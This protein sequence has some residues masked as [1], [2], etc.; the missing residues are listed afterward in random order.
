MTPVRKDLIL[1]TRLRKLHHMGI[2]R[3]Q[4]D[5]AAALALGPQ[6]GL[7]CTDRY[8]EHSDEQPVWFSQLPA[9]VDMIPRPC[10]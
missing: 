5:S 10:N 9:G 8:I 4:N 2:N 6:S 1:L 7:R 3:W